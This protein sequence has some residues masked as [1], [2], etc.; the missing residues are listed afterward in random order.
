MNVTTV[1]YYNLLILSSLG[2]QEN[3][4]FQK[5]K[6][7]PGD[8]LHIGLGYDIFIICTNFGVFS[9]GENRYDRLGIDSIEYA[10]T[11]IR[12]PDDKAKFYT[13]PT[14]YNKKAKSA[15]VKIV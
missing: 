14:S 3:N 5:L 7:P 6:T 8:C 12:I 11:W 1:N 4:I 13:G 15:N 9:V 10:L 2:I